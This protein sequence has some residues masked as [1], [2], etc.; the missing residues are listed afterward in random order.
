MSVQE[1]TE[2]LVPD[3]NAEAKLYDHADSKEA[4]INDAHKEGVDHAKDE[5][6]KG[7]DAQATSQEASKE[8]VVSLKLGDDYLI[9]EEHLKSVEEFA[10][11]NKLSSDAAQKL[12]DNQNQL[13]K[14]YITQQEES[15]WKEVSSWEEQLKTDKDFGG[16][17][18]SENVTYAQT[19]F[20]KYADTET[21]KLFEEK[22][23]GN[24]P[25]LVKMFARIGKE[26][27]GDTFV[28][29]QSNAQAP[30]SIEDLFYGKNN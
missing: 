14:N 11:A 30:R 2:A 13:V 24:Y 27:S 16:E 9:T 20:R 1:N 3:F 8:E 12:L 4:L 23:Y 28:K 22:G 7:Q 26:I 15:Y 5:G 19:A 10:K 17:K 25:G 6:E 18:Y 21:Q 29:G